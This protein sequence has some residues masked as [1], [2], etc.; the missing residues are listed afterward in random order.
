MCKLLPNR[1]NDPQFLSKGAVSY[2]YRVNR[3]IAVK[4]PVTEE[5]KEF[6]HENTI[7]DELDREPRYTDV[8][9]SFLRLPNTNFMV[10]YSGGTLEQRLRAY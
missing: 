8:I 10:F 7:L 2:I 6:R 9:Q 3:R 4:I 5:H 1:T